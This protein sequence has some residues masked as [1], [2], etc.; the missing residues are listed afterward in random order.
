VALTVA[1]IQLSGISFFLVTWIGLYQFAAHNIVCLAN[2]P[3]QRHDR[4]IPQLT[5]CLSSERPWFCSRSWAWFCCL[6]DLWGHVVW[7]RSQCYDEAIMRRWWGSHVDWRRSQGC[8]D[9]VIYSRGGHKV[10][11][12]LWWCDHEKI[13]WSRRGHVVWTKGCHKA[14]MWFECGHKVVMW[15]GGGHK[16][17]MNRSQG[18]HEAVMR[19][20]WGGDEVVMWSGSHH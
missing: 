6:E 11:M 5:L 8:H 13:M 3:Q 9:A 18:C 14:F 16:A 20:S 15:S 19:L 12:L 10:V 17:I 2:P 7:R 1:L 4:L